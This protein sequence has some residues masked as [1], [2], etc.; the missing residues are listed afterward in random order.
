MFLLIAE[1]K[2][3]ARQMLAFAGRGLAGD[4]ARNKLRKRFVIR[5][6]VAMQAIIACTYSPAFA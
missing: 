5:A 2:A 1:F 4:A 6:A 3:A